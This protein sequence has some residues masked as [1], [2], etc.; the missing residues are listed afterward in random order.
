VKQRGIGLTE[1]L[2]GLLL[3]S[4]IMLSLSQ[5]YLG[6]KKQYQLM[7][8]KLAE[9]FD[10]QWVSM[11][12]RNSISQA[13]FTPCLRLDNLIRDQKQIPKSLI[14]ENPP[15]QGISIRKMAIPFNQ[16]IKFQSPTRLIVSKNTPIRLHHALI[17]A[18]CYHAEIAIPE[19][20]R[21]VGQEQY[22][23]LK[24]SLSFDYLG[25]IYLGEWINEKWYIKINASNQKSLFYQTSRSEELS[26]LIHSLQFTEHQAEDKHWIKVELILDKDKKSELIVR[27]RNR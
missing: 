14:I 17:I 1:V 26:P 21:V 10:V 13:G 19:S 20:V 18:D 7:Q 27:M 22:L 9:A 5:M 6:C 23:T 4:L 12:L 25:S 3:S 24:K 11:L 15:F 2:V 8:D 16:V